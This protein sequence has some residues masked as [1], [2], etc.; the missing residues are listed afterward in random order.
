M[1]DTLSNAISNKDINNIIYKIILKYSNYYELEDLYQVAMIGLI[2]AHKNYNSNYNVKFST[3]AYNYIFGEVYEYVNANKMI[4]VG[5]EYQKLYK[6]INESKNILTQK[7]MRIPSNYELALFLEIDESL[8]ENVML[9]YEN[10][11]SLDRTISSDDKDVYLY[12]VIA[13]KEDN[14]LDKLYLY[15]EINKLT[16][17]EKKLLE[18]RYFMDKSQQE[19]STYLGINQVQVSRYE[20]KILK[21]MNENMVN[22]VKK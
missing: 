10:V 1:T 12:D 14:Y 7:L 18:Y 15:D 2:K 13:S 3:Y 11:D 4:K 19:V 21:K 9:L 6:K 8:I 22:N 16:D 17:E 20:K 5:K